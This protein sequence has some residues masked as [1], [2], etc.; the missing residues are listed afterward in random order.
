MLVA[1][2]AIV[3]L[4]QLITFFAL[5]YIIFENAKI[6]L[7]HH[8]NL[9]SKSTIDNINNQSQ[10]LKNNVELL[11]NDF[12]LREAL[13]TQDPQTIQTALFNYGQRTKTDLIFVIDE[14]QNITSHIEGS[15]NLYVT[16]EQGNAS[17]AILP[18]L[19]SGIEPSQPQI[20]FMVI[21]NRLYQTSISKVVSPNVHIGIGYEITVNTI[22]EQQANFI[23]DISLFAG[24]ANT[25]E[26]QYF[27]NVTRLD[28]TLDD[29]APPI[30][31][32]LS[33]ERLTENPFFGARNGEDFINRVITLPS[34]NNDKNYFAVLQIP[35][36]SALSEYMYY[37]P[38]LSLINLGLLIVSL[39]F[40]YIVTSQISRPMQLILSL[41]SQIK[42]GNYNI[43]IPSSLQGP[44]ETGQLARE[45]KEMGEGLQEREEMRSLAFYD[46]LTDLPNRRFIYNEIEDVIAN[47][48]PSSL[49]ML[50][51]NQFKV[52]NN[53][54]GQ[55]AGDYILRELSARLLPFCEDENILC[56][57]LRG[58]DFLILFTGQEYMS[59]DTLMMIAKDILIKVEEPY[60]FQEQPINI[61]VRIGACPINYTYNQNNWLKEVDVACQESNM[62]KDHIFIA[63]AE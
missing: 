35:I 33:Y 52:T 40:I 48:T 11:T 28:T 34:N 1:T 9:I 61:N 23:T 43:S 32:K 22:K 19:D 51:I 42:A 59:P 63:A 37:K 21:H 8:L 57:R 26:Q 39:V 36:N 49:M 55:D 5:N 27:E 24:L 31:P 50:D 47:K 2:M 13:F 53:I 44:D 14:D 62:V 25:L 46:S 16:S 56:A 45:I 30:F 17:E 29:N 54:Y 20:F 4:I 12:A 38:Y 60:L 3:F 15:S 18:L 6:S 7:Q 41:T 58:D 10:I